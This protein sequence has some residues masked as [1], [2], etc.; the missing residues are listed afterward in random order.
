MANIAFNVSLGRT[1]ELVHRV[2]TNDPANAAIVVLAIVANGATDAE[3][4]D[5]PTV[6]DVLATAAAEA[7][8]GGYARQVLTDADLADF[9]TDNA[10]DRNAVDTPDLN[11]GPIDVGDDWTDLLFAYDPDIT[12]AGAQ[13]DARL[14]PL[15]LHDYPMKSD[16]SAPVTQVPDFLHAS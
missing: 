12:D 5:C 3:L 7:T 6:A 15:T 9:V 4:K 1:V 13:G 14:V 10:N 8:N 2:K 16:G 11:W